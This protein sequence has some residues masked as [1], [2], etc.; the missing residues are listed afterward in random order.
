MDK[1]LNKKTEDY[2]CEFK[3]QICQEIKTLSLSDGDKTNIITQIMEYPRLVFDKEDFSKRKR[4]KNQ[5]PVT[6]RCAAKRA[7]GQQCTRRKQ[8]NCDFCGTHFKSAPNGI[9]S[10]NENKNKKIEVFNQDICGI[11]YYVD[12]NKNIYKME[13]IVQNKINPQI[14]GKYK[15]ENGNYTLDCLY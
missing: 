4:V 15:V 9:A 14:I 5:I 2:F 12:H 11:I 13:D 7:D 8:D 3:N 1:R 6:N 10:D